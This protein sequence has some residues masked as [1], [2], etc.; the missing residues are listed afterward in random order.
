MQTCL[1][2]NQPSVEIL[3]PKKLSRTF[4]HCEVCQL[5]FVDSSQFIKKEEEKH[6]YA[7]HKNG[8]QYPGY[9]QF[10]NQALEPALPLLNN[11]MHGLDFGCGPNPTLSVLL[12]QHGIRCDDYD[13][14]FFNNLPDT[15]YDFIFATECFEHFFDP[16]KEIL[17]IHELLKPQGLLVI[18]T[19][20]WGILSDFPNWYYI[21]DV[22]HVCFFHSETM[23]YIANEFG[24]ELLSSENPRV[25]IM[26]KN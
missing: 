5:I 21:K 16:K 24:F 18:M 1:L 11:K 22:T 14:L 2:C 10:L 6:R 15:A 17:R 9:V 23:D 19:E 4:F 8:I 25:T 3:S 20:K 26:R 12:G 7:Q 13:P